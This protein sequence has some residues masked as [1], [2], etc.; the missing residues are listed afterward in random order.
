MLKLK[1]TKKI[2]EPVPLVKLIPNIITLL[3]LI[4]GVSSIRFALD[5]KWELAAYC[6]LIATILDGLDG[7]IARILNATSHFGAEL[8]SLCDFANF[9]LCPAFLIYLWSFQQFEYKVTS[10]SAIV[11]FIVCMSIRL[12]RFNTTI[13][14][15]PDSKLA[16]MFFTGIPAPSGA[17]LA[18]T[19]M[20]VDFEISTRFADFN[21]RHYT[22]CINLYIAI[23]ALLMVSRLPTISLKYI[24]IKPEYLPLSLGIFGILIIATIIYPWYTIPVVAII[25]LLSI[26]FCIFISKKIMSNE[27]YQNQ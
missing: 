5:S 9:G 24:K 25:Y 21:I 14:K 17:L 8:D 6:I 26:P 20:I 4:V 12:A 23:I 19:P 2:L 1:K 13:G 18:L 7:R 27:H 15:T 11:L 16:K 10:W 22:L 3:G